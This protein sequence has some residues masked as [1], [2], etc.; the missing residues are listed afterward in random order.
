MAV[1]RYNRPGYGRV[2]TSRQKPPKGPTA[3]EGLRLATTPAVEAGDYDRAA[4]LLEVPLELLREHRDRMGTEPQGPRRRDASSI[5]VRTHDEQ[6]P[7][8]PCPLCRI[9]TRRN[10]W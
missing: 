2:E 9:R 6:A 10:H 4:M 1:T 7:S 5:R 8:G 3:K